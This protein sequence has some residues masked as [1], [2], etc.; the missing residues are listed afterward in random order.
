MAEKLSGIIDP[1]IDVR[2]VK[3]QLLHLRGPA[4]ARLATR[5]V[6]GLDAYI[7]TRSDGRVVIVMTMHARGKGSGA[8]CVRACGSSAAVACT[9]SG[10]H[11]DGGPRWSER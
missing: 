11:W 6:R 10:K 8:S 1:P 7:V 5:N 9:G 3:G 2:P 4:E